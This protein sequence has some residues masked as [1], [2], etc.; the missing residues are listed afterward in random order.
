[1]T[2]C[3]FLSFAKGKEEQGKEIK[4]IIEASILA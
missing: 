3:M 1:M 4:Q 2:E